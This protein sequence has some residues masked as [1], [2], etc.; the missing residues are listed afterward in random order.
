GSG[1]CGGHGFTLRKLRRSID[2]SPAAKRD[3]SPNC[4]RESFCSKEVIYG[5]RQCRQERKGPRKLESCFHYLDCIIN[6]DRVQRAKVCHDT[7]TLM[8]VVLYENARL[9]P[10]EQRQNLFA[11]I[12]E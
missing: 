7:G 4:N 6:R 2:S 1:G 11:G 12:A 8:D 9:M 10:E 5:Q 3:C